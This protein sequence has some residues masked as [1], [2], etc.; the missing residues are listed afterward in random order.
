MKDC[1]NNNLKVKLVMFGSWKLSAGTAPTPLWST[2]KCLEGSSWTALSMTLTWCIGCLVNCPLKCLPIA[3]QFYQ[4]SKKL[5]TMTM[6]LWHLNFQVVSYI[7]SSGQVNSTNWHFL[8]GSIAN[9]DQSR[10]CSY[11]YDQR[12][13]VFGD[14]G[15]IRVENDN[16]NTTI[17][18]TAQGDIM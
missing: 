18:T 16:P 1:Y 11:G 15:M 8:Q 7:I 2:W 6:L 17:T 13:E 5:E 14:K 10:F 4:K 9:I 12:L 3:M